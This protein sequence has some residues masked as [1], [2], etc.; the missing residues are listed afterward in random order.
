VA[1]LVDARTATSDVWVNSD[2]TLSV[3]TYASPH[4]FQ[5][6]GSTDWSPIDPELVVDAGRADRVRSKATRGLV[7]FGPAGDPAGMQQ[8]EVDGAVVGFMPVAADPSVVP[9]TKGSTA[10]YRDLWFATD[11]V[12]GVS[13]E[14]TDERLVLKS[15]G[16]PT[17]FAFDVSGATPRS[18]GRHGVELVVDG[19][20]VASIPPLTVETSHG[21]VD[22]E[23]AG[24]AFSIEAG[25]RGS[26]G[27]LRVSVSSDWMAALPAEAF[28][29]VIDPTVITTTI[30]VQVQ[31]FRA[32]ATGVS[33]TLEAG[34]DGSLQTWRGAAYVPIPDPA[35]ISPGGTQPWNLEHAWMTIDRQVGSTGTGRSLAL[36]GE[37]L[38]PTSFGAVAAGQA[39]FGHETGTSDFAFDVTPWVATHLGAGAWYGFIGDEDTSHGSNLHVLSGPGGNGISIE[40]TFAQSSPPTHLVSP[41][42]TISTTTP[43]LTAEVVEPPDPDSVWDTVYYDFKI[44]TEPNGAGTVIDSGWIDSPSWKVPPGALVDGMTYH[45]RVWN[46]IGMPWA[47]GSAGYFPPA[48]PTVTTALVVKQRLGA[49]GP[50]PTDTVGSVPGSTATPAKGAPS[51]GTAPASVTVNLVTGNLAASVNTHPLSTLSGAAGV[52]LSYDSLGPAGLQGGQRGLYGRYFSGGSLIGQRLDPSINFSWAG[53]PMGGYV[54]SGAPV[55]VEWTG[56]VTVPAAG[57]S[58]HLGGSVASGSMTIYLDGATVPYATLGSGST[59]SF[60]SVLGWSPGSAHAIRVEYAGGGTSVGQLWARDDGAPAGQPAEFVVPGGW[61]APRA[62]GLPAG[63]RLSANPYAG[64][65]TRLEDLG[66]HAVL[67]SA[68]GETALFVRR[69]DGSYA[70]PPASHDLLTVATKTV[71][72]VVTAGEFQLSTSDNFLFTFS[73][74]GWVRSVVSVADDRRP[75]ALQYTYATVPGT[76]GAPVLTQI[77]DPVA[78]RS[79]GL[80]YGAATCDGGDFDTSN[81]PEGML[82]RIEHW[83][84]TG[85]APSYTTLVYD[86]SGRMVRVI[87]PGGVIADFGYDSAGR[88]TQIR[89]PLANDALAFNRRPL[90][91]PSTAASTPICATIIAYDTTGRVAS[92]TQPTPRY[93]A[94]RPARFYGYTP[95]ARTAKVT[96]AGFNPA[97][98]FA[99]TVTWDEQ[100]RIVTQADSVGRVTRTI[101]DPNVDRPLAT[102]DPAGLQTT[103]VYDAFAQT[104]TDVYGP[105]PSSC[106][107][108]SF[109]YTPTG[110]ACSVAVPRTQHRYDEGIHDLA[111]TFWGNPYFAGAPQKHGTGPGGTGPAG[112]AGCAPDTFCTQWNTLPVTPNGGSCCADSQSEFTWTM[113]LSGTITLPA[114]AALYVATTQHATVYIDE[115]RALDLDAQYLDEGQGAY[116]QWAASAVTPMLTAGPH[117]LRIDYLGSTNTLNALNLGGAVGVPSGG[118]STNLLGPDYGLETSTIDPDGK[119]VATS[120]SDPAAGVGPELGL[121]TA[122]TQDPGGLALTTTTAYENPASDRWLRK[123]GTTLPGGT[124]TLDTHYCGQPGATNCGPDQIAGAIATACGV[125]A[126]TAQYGLLA[127]RSDPDPNPSTDGRQQQYLYDRAGRVV[128]HRTAPA[129]TISSA[130]WECTTYDQRGRI[131]SQTWPTRD[132]LTPGRIVTYNYI[133]AS[134]P[135]TT[136]VTDPTGTITA[137]VDL[138]GRPVSYTDAVG[139]TTLYTYDQVGR[140]TTTA[141]PQSS[142]SNTYD[143]NTGQL[144]AV[145][146]NGQATVRADISYHATTGRMTSVAYTGGGAHMNLTVGY[147]GYGTQT[148]VFFEDDAIPDPQ[149][150]AGHAVTRSPGGRQINTLIDTG[151]ANLVD[152]NP[153]GDDLIYDGSGRL[154]SAFLDGGRADYSYAGDPTCPSIDPGANP[155]AGANTNRASVTWTPT[156]GTATTTRSCFNQADQLIA[157]TTDGTTTTGYGYDER[158][159]QLTDGT[160]TYTWDSANR[161]TQVSAAGPTVVTYSRDALDRTTRRTQGAATTRY[162]YNGYNDSPAAVLD[163]N[164]DL[165]QQVVQLPGGVLVTIDNPSLTK[166]WSFPDLQGHYIATTDNNGDPISPVVTYDPWGAQTPTG[167]PL[168]NTT[169]NADLG[170]FG[171]AGKLEEHATTKPIILMGARPYTPTHGRFLTIDPIQGGCANNYVYVHGDPVNSS[172]LS[173]MGG[174]GDLWDA[175]SNIWDATGGKLVHAVKCDPIG[176]L[177]VAAGVVGTI[178]SGPVGWTATV[179]AVGGGLYTTRRSV[180]QGDMAGAVL[181]AVSVVL[182]GGA[183]G[184]KLG[185]HVVARGTFAGLAAPM[186]AYY[187]AASSSSTVLSAG[188]SRRSC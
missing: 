78:G 151:A 172:D 119:T 70:A 22:P 69:A 79:I 62:T 81:A 88:L 55:T 103:K 185:A 111:A 33:G 74:E 21:L 140:V 122:V 124:T 20:V 17:S 150:I 2:G 5:A 36:L 68:T 44:S 94:P 96:V 97:G 19:N 123:T 92:V 87:N 133:V 90:D 165:V 64:A 56:T 148:S 147:D 115:V 110:G 66:S 176:W 27:R 39:L 136:S 154:T 83:D 106:F 129:N 41:S 13:G 180:R 162:A 30:P 132:A 186:M 32:G 34:V 46:N 127:Q 126:G 73:R 98:G 71:A 15:A 139:W 67:H 105:A 93:N 181:G 49:G 86:S 109:P 14:G 95:D 9:V 6:R 102:I 153:A 158:G 155:T 131:T 57:G 182:G 179:I 108:T 107:S 167:T 118:V 35:Q 80:C 12:Y 38:Q 183:V 100:G 143:P 42:G 8:V 51:P 135:L 23:A 63:W 65:W 10:T 134:D 137:T 43:V 61:L 169:G 76:V 45:V 85:S 170:P 37:P 16:A 157:T 152:P 40:Y 99:S 184:L 166:T 120:Y 72:G 7:S 168:D 104:L 50:S 77:T 75:T 177:S 114:A 89:D 160:D 11:A 28:P 116:G 121:R 159:N 142:L 175:A 52:T 26:G 3:T 187:Y 128:G 146:L 178:A 112:V 163:T 173:G 141:F 82:A 161:L 54:V 156:S 174:L 4:H 101:W 130:P 24:A 18:D 91:C 164:Y 25:P 60:G 144:S 149:R 59:L 48:A 171:S 145:Q 47:P 1:E 53:S 84:G 117:R 58:W 125:T 188:S 29:V 138:L 113:R 31:S